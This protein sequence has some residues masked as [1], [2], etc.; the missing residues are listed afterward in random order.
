MK[1]KNAHCY[2]TGR[3]G[4]CPVSTW[5][6]IFIMLFTGCTDD[7]FAP[8]NSNAPDG[9][10]R[11]S[12]HT[13]ADDFS[14]PVS[15][16]GSAEE[17][18]NPAL[19]PYVLVFAGTDETATFVEVKQAEKPASDMYVELTKQTTGNYRLLV[20]ANAPDNFFNGTAEVAFNT[21][22]LT[23]A[24]AGKTLLQAENLL[25]AKQLTTPSEPNIPYTNPS[26][27]LPMSGI[28]ETT[29]GITGSLKIGTNDVPFLLTRIVAKVIVKVPVAIPDFTLTAA[30]AIHVPVTGSFY[31]N[32][33]SAIRDNSA[34]GAKTN[35]VNGSDVA[36]IANADFGTVNTPDSTATNPIYIYESGKNAGTAIIIKASYKTAV[37]KYYKI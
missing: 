6:M 32:S 22:T 25:L 18:V 1:Q 23:A 14:L 17:N 29:A 3:D 36:G 15:R 11:L 27:A 4:A 2:R 35:Y 30:G 24:L 8:D 16:A 9:L 20:I 34:V 5:V 21:T 37:N 26:T 7:R 19:L 31:R 12:L 13:N 33:T 10:V 28:K